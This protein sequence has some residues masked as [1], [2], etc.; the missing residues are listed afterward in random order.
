MNSSVNIKEVLKDI[1]VNKIRVSD[2]VANMEEI[3][4]ESIQYIDLIVEIEDYFNIEIPDTFLTAPSNWRMN[5][6]IDII[7]KKL[8]KDRC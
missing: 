3:Q 5:T 4:L 7:E 2:D 6:L 8:K 1:L